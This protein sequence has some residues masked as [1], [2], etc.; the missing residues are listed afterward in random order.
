MSS[1]DQVARLL[2]LAPYVL[3]HPGVG[4]E[5]AAKKFGVTSAQILKDLSILWM[6]GLPNNDGGDLIEVD[7]EAAESGGIIVIDNADYL[8]RPMRFTA[9]EAMGLVVALRAIETT[10]TGSAKVAAG[11]AM[12]KLRESMGE[13]ADD[14]VVITLEAG[15][16]AVRATL[17]EGIEQQ[18]RVRLTYDGSMR[19]VTTTPEVDPVRI[20][21]RDG[22]AYL[23]AWS[24]PR[25]AWRTYRLDRIRSAD[26]L[27]RTSEEHGDE[28]SWDRGWFDP[29]TDANIVTLDL[30]PRA[31]WITEYYPTTHVAETDGGRVRASFV[32]GDPA[33]LTSL[34]LR[35]GGEA[36]V[37]DPDG[38]GDGAADAA[39]E[40]LAAY[41]ASGL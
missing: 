39:R 6:C 19:G 12:A 11:S 26:L 5:E 32:V 35:L 18:R 23:S 34:L 38:A 10:A 22:A 28:P 8:A 15:E 2:A 17:V 27:D 41:E 29:T 31:R 30:D 24:V 13:L 21:V 16:E 37:V 20:V 1:V 36:R 9:D 4:V 25:D 33:W 3:N 40:T 14:R 7:M